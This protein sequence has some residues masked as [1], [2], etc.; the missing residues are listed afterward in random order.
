MRVGLA[1]TLVCALVG[2]PPAY[3]ARAGDHPKL[4]KKLNERTSQGGTSRV[5]VMLKPGWTADAET[6][7]LGGKLGRSLDSINGK[8]AELPNGQLKKLADY[9]GVERIVWD[10]PLDSKMNRVAITVGARSVNDNLGY[11]GAGVGVAVIDSG[12]TSWHDDL[13]YVGSNAAVRGEE[14][15]ARCGLCRLRRGAL[16]PLR[17]LRPRHA[18]LGHHLR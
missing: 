16:D 10:R 12:I 18:R 14:R 7:K 3:A 17:R 1:A 6:K 15:T 4:D 11:R 8:V 13:G 5:I 2:A 9:A